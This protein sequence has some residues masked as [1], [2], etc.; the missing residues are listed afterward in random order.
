MAEELETSIDTT[1]PKPKVPWN[2]IPSDDCVIH[3]SQIIQDGQVVHEGEAI[4]PHVGESVAVLAVTTVGEFITVSK[5]I[6]LADE[7]EDVQATAVALGGHFEKLC[8]SLSKRIVQ[9]TWT[10]MMGQ[11]MGQPYNRPD[12]LAG[13]SAEEIVYLAGL[14]GQPQTEEMRKNGSAPSADTS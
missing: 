12:I 13:V 11:P 1:E 6:G 14:S 3:P 8:L 7:N 4:Y 5:L 2:T 10:D 9:W